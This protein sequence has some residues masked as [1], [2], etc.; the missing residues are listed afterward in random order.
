MKKIITIALFVGTLMSTFGATSLLAN[1]DSDTQTVEQKAQKLV[2]DAKAKAKALIEKAKA[3]A[4]ALK[5]QAH[6]SMND[7]SKEAKALAAQT[8]QKVKQKKDELADKTTAT[9]QHV[10]EGTKDKL[11]YTKELVNKSV[12]KTKSTINDALILSSI[13]YAY[14]TS[15]GIHSTKIDVDVKDGVVKLFGKVSSQKEAQEAMTIAFLTKGVW[16]VES[17]FVIEK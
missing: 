7:T 5:A 12:V 9:L 16:A 11:V 17:F 1:S 2:E 13:K 8:L 10:K 15:P 6:K 4:A 3:D 14:L